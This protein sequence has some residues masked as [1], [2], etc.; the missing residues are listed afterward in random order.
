MGLP[1]VHNKTCFSPIDLSYTN[2]IN[3]PAK[4]TWK[5]RGKKFP[6]LQ[7]QPLLSFEN[8]VSLNYPL[9][10]FLKSL[11]TVLSCPVVDIFHNRVTVLIT[12]SDS[13]HM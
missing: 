5:G 1:Y 2:L 13:I 4:R 9:N 7:K 10:L 6:P 11:S 3:R 8:P 12:M